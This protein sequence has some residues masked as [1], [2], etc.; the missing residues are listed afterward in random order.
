MSA[1]NA[2][3]VSYQI[4]YGQPPDDWA[5]FRPPR[6]PRVL[7]IVYSLGYIIAYPLVCTCVLAILFALWIQPGLVQSSFWPMY[8]TYPILVVIVAA[9]PFFLMWLV[10][11][12]EKRDRDTLI[13]LLP[14]G[15]I[16]YKP[17]SNERKRRA[18]VIEYAHVEAI[19]CQKKLAGIVVNISGKDGN[20]EK[21]FITWKYG[22]SSPD[23]LVHQE[24]AHRIVNDQCSVREGTTPEGNTKAGDQ[25]LPNDKW[26]REGKVS[27]RV[28]LRISTG[29]AIAAPLVTLVGAAVET[30]HWDSRTLF[31]DKGH[32]NAVHFVAWSP[33][34][35]RISS[36]GWDRVAHIWN[37]NAGGLPL[38]TYQQ[39][40]DGVSSAA[41]SPDG[42]LLVSDGDKGLLHIW[43][44]STGKIRLTYTAQQADGLSLGF[45]P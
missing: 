34:G 8:T 45:S 41:W 42:K 39:D 27:R 36:A 18:K 16:Q 33:D 44:A 26:L 6:Y 15:F 17:W 37:G 13:V 32:T 10:W 14:E 5:V 29:L 4:Q 23:A 9:F 2:D 20:Q 19:M 38:V 21:V 12:L 7:L 11:R 43:E 1:I 35:T 3:E 40:S 30:V 24:I 22:G 28:L 31:T 25:Q